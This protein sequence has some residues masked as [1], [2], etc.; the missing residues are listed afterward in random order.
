[1]ERSFTF[2][3]RRIVVHAFPHNLHIPLAPE[4]VVS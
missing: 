2:D 4:R 3:V 1:M